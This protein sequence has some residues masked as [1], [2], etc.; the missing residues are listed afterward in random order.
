MGYSWFMGTE[1]TTF[2]T[3]M[4]TIQNQLEAAKLVLSQAQTEYQHCFARGDW[5]ACSKAKRKVAKCMKEVQYLVAQK[6]A[7]R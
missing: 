2:N 6:L 7:L 4:E 3:T 5:A 1:P